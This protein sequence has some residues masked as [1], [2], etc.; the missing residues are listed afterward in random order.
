M[1]DTPGSLQREAAIIDPHLPEGYSADPEALISDPAQPDTRSGVSESQ[2]ESSLMLQGGDIHRHLQDQG[3][4][5]RPTTCGDLL[6]P[7][8]G[9]LG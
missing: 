1:S 8:P 6:W 4:S 2:E 5:Q 9:T 7:Q 3:T